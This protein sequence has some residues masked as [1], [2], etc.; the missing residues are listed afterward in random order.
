[1][2]FKAGIILKYREYFFKYTIFLQSLNRLY[3][4]IVE[5]WS[6]D[7]DLIL[8]F[9]RSLLALD[10]GLLSSRLEEVVFGEYGYLTRYY[11]ER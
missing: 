7:T 4:T 9:N 2:Y 3:R 10:D 11:N 6:T 5:F 8:N 1:M